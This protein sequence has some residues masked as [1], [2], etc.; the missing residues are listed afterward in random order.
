MAGFSDTG[1]EPRSAQEILADYQDNFSD[2]YGT[3]NFSPGT[4]MG[5]LIK[6][7]ALKEYKMEQLIARAIEALTIEGA[8]GI[9]LEMHGYNVGIY[10]RGEQY[11]EG[12]VEVTANIP[13]SDISLY[14]TIYTSEDGKVFY[15]DNLNSVVP[16]VIEMIRSSGSDYD[17]VPSPYSDLYQMEWAN[18]QSDNGGISYTDYI[19]S[20]GDSWIQWTDSSQPDA[21]NKYYIKCSGYVTVSD[22]I[23]AEKPGIDYNIG[24]NSI[25]SFSNNPSLS[26][27]NPSITNS[28]ATTGGTE[29]E[30]DGEFRERIWK[31]KRRSFTLGRVKDIASNVDG[32]RGLR[33]YQAAG[34][35]QYSLSNWADTGSYD[36]YERVTGNTG[37]IGWRKINQRFVPGTGII[38]YNQMVFY[39]KRFGAPPDL[40][41]E[42]WVGSNFLGSGVFS[43]YDTDPYDPNGWQ[44]LEIPLKYNGLDRSHTYKLYLSC[45]DPTIETGNSD[46]WTG[47][48]WAIATGNIAGTLCDTEQLFDE[49]TTT[50]SNSIF[51]TRFP[52]AYYNIDIALEEGYNIDNVKD[53]I[54]ELLSTEKGSGFSPLGIQYIISQCAEISIECKGTVFIPN[55]A[56]ITTVRNRLESAI[57]SY[58]ENLEPGE[59]VIYSKIF[60]IIMNDIEVWK[61]ER[62]QIRISDTSW[63]D[64]DIKI[65]DQEVATL[66]S[67]W[68]NTNF[69]KG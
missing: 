21:N 52:G 55:T 62:L 11:A 57:D 54:E 48:Y 63:T 45:S 66:A 36:Q 42:L 68:S 40:I 46:W 14:Q 65:R 38:G 69:L 35:D 59:N 64:T 10:K 47:N 28:T 33:V 15:N 29:E 41:C 23:I 60:S 49:D 18:S 5:Q 44:D 16:S 1:F 53:D 20:K 39:G 56:N 22:E 51:K 6:I 31:A 2:V 34:T 43:T 19:Y 25:T 27:L 26:T 12:H 9:F 67:T 61:L 50:N 24:V 4:F 32:V 8:Y 3:V 37:H 58:L 7:I 13:A 30:E 17:R